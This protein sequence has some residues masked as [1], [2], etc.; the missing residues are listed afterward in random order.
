[1]K[2]LLL[3]LLALVLMAPAIAMAEDKAANTAKEFV[4]FL[5]KNAKD[6]HY[7]PSGWMGDYGD[8]K[9]NDQS[10]ENPHSGAWGVPFTK[11][12]TLLD[13]ISFSIRARVELGILFG[14]RF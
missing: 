12:T 14:S 6:N 13:R 5:D 10:A 7:I 4:V 8:I 2:K 9:M 3:V 1:M 11:S